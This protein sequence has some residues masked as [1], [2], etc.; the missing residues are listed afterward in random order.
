MAT[1]HLDPQHLT[2]IFANAAVCH[3]HLM[4]GANDQTAWEEQSFVQ[5]HLLRTIFIEALQRAV[6]LFTQ[7]AVWAISST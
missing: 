4:C 5:Q 2:C 6:G 1:S 3:I 7:Q